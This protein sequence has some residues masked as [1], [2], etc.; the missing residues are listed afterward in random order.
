MLQKSL[1]VLSLVSLMFLC[2]FVGGVVGYSQGTGTLPFVSVESTLPEVFGNSSLADIQE[3]VESDET[4]LREY[5]TGFNCVEYA[6]L[7]ARQAHWEGIPAESIR[8]TF[9][10]GSAHIILAFPTTDAGWIF[11]DPGTDTVIKPRVGGQIGGR[12]IQ[13]VDILV[14][15]W[16]P[17]IRSSN[18]Y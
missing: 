11:I 18:E 1:R 13:A 10:D 2:G 8:L 17:F 14:C 4:N 7:M 5:D 6:I 16:K 3:F 15:D 12:T 9:S